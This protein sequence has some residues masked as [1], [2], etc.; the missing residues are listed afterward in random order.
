[1]TIFHNFQWRPFASFLLDDNE[2]TRLFNEIKYIQ[3]VQFFTANGG[4][5][6]ATINRYKTQR[7]FKE[8]GNECM[9]ND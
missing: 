1:M 2:L 6:K 7:K 3:I 4:E 5:N 8:E 9:R